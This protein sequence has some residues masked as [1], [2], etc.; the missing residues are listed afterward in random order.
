[1]GLHQAGRVGWNAFLSHSLCK[2][3]NLV[4]AATIAHAGISLIRVCVM[5]ASSTALHP[6]TK[7]L[8]QCHVTCAGDCFDNLHWRIEG[9]RQRDI[10]NRA[11]VLPGGTY[12]N[13]AFLPSTGN[14]GVYAPV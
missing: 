4:P 8:T 2:F 1:M 3:P 11:G 9:D 14:E 7:D 13:I 12:L 6:Q 5:V 10:C